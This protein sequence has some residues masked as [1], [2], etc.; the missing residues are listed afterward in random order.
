[1]S[2]QNENNTIFYRNSKGKLVNIFIFFMKF[3][4]NIL[5]IIKKYIK[6]GN[7][8]FSFKQTFS[9]LIFS[10][11]QFKTPKNVSKK[12]IKLNND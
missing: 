9:N 4:Y 10:T 11:L 12:L 8:S 7:Y 2:Y 1:M 3:I 5:C 6:F